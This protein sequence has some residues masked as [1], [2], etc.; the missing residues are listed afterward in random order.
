V[1][2]ASTNPIAQ[3]RELGVLLLVLAALLPVLANLRGAPGPREIVLDFGPGDGPYTR[4]FAVPNPESFDPYEIEGGLTTHWTTHAARVVLPLEVEVKAVQLELRFARHLAD[5]GFVDLRLC[6]IEGERIAVK[7]GFQEYRTTFALGGRKPLALDLRIDA[8]D[9]RNLGLSMDWARFTVPAG[10]RVRLSGGGLRP[11]V[12]LLLVAAI[13]LV[14]GFSARSV[15]LLVFPLCLALAAGVLRDPFLT[16]RLLRGLPEALLLLVLPAA[17]L[18]RWSRRGSEPTPTRFATALLVFVFLLRAGA[19]NH[20]SFYNPDL[21]IHAGLVKVVRE[22]GFDL[23]RAPAGWLYTPRE[24]RKQEGPAVRATSGLW[25]RSL[26]GVSFGLPYS[27]A[28]HAL[29][30][31]L[32]LDYDG[33]LTALKVLG[34]FA[35]ALPAALLVFLAPRVGAPAWAGALLGSAPTAGAELSLGAVPAVFG[36]AADVAF[37]LLVAVRW[38]TMGARTSVLLTGLLVAAVELA[39]VSSAL[40]V[41]LLAAGLAGLSLAWERTPEVLARV[42]GLVGAVAFG[43][44]LALLLYYRDFLPGSLIALRLVGSGGG[45]PLADPGGHR[46]ASALLAWGL[47]VLPLLALAG[48]F[49]LV[50]E[51]VSGGLVPVVPAWALTAVVLGSLQWRHPA[52]FGFLHLPLFVTPLIALGAARALQAIASRGRAAFILA[53]VL[54]AGLG[55]QGAWLQAR[56]IGAELVLAP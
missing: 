25:L 11:S 18:I 45:E 24:A 26:R 43:S 9:D 37:L 28:P 13:L 12:M 27:L 34:A 53:V 52:V 50:R 46:V 31:P 29:L 33:L 15:L 22:A 5:K 2:P 1:T 36:H 30:A 20:P 47:P 44:L 48:I 35:S 32:P 6:G 38:H 8:R 4:G 42:R 21:R 17:G 10:G 7:R 40:L 39:Y 49:L 14:A 19:L 16:V 3:G 41:P 23:L 55:L 51:G 54:A 56:S